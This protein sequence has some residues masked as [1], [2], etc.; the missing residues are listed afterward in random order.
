MLTS[1]LLEKVTSK[2][3]NKKLPH[4]EQERYK[5]KLMTW[6]VFNLNLAIRCWNT[7]VIQLEIFKKFAHLFK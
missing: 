1:E 5:I 2:K 4:Q 3:W 7:D 6:W